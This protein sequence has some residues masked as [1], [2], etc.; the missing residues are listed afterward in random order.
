M[1]DDENLCCSNDACDA[2]HLNELITRFVSLIMD[3]TSLNGSE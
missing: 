1:C 3:I 2:S